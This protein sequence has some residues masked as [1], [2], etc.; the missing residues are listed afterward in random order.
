MF[1]PF[2]LTSQKS[3][4]PTLPLL[5]SLPSPLALIPSFPRP[6]RLLP[7][8]VHGHSSIF[9][10]WTVARLSPVQGFTQPHGTT[11]PR[12]PR[13]ALPFRWLPEGRRAQRL[14]S[15]H[16]P[17]T[18]PSWAA[19]T[20]TAESREPQKGLFHPPH[21]K[22]S[23]HLTVPWSL[24]WGYVQQSVGLTPWEPCGQSTPVTLIGT[25]IP[26]A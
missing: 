14:S 2:I 9:I 17:L 19:S 22:Y 25:V 8:S 24:H 12:S 15:A 23:L 4:P 10:G 1:P 16:C 26:K 7:P 18:F 13:P 5:P 20:S 11:V 3:G 6:K 21:F